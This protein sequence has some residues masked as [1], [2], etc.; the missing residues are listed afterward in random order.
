MTRR[1]I[2]DDAER[3]FLAGLN[4]QG[5]GPLE[6]VGTEQAFAAAADTHGYDP[7]RLSSAVRS[8]ADKGLIEPL[9]EGRL[10]M[11]KD[12]YLASH[13]AAEA[14]KAGIVPF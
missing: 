1:W 10:R 11:S 6:T 3:A 13:Q 14:L 9:E 8:L 7:Q 5:F 12:G 4:A 2:L